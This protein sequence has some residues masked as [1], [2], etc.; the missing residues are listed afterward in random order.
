MS[1]DQKVEERSFGNIFRFGKRF[2]ELEKSFKK[3]IRTIIIIEGYIFFGLVKN[4]KLPAFNFFSGRIR[5]VK[6]W[7]SFPMDLRMTPRY[8]KL[9]FKYERKKIVLG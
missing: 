1:T 4:G 6:H 7:C 3:I 9:M 2:W 5:L 8:I